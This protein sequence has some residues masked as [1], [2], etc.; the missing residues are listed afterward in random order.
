MSPKIYSPVSRTELFGKDRTLHGLFLL[1]NC[2]FIFIISS[3]LANLIITTAFFL[4]LK[5]RFAHFFIL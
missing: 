4:S 3:E 5:D 1:K 2:L